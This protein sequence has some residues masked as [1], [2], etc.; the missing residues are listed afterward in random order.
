MESIEMQDLAAEATPPLKQTDLQ[1]GS[2]S[3]QVNTAVPH[4]FWSRH[5]RIIIEEEE[6][7]DHLGKNRPASDSTHTIC[8]FGVDFQ[9]L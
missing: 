1:S 3:A 2:Q 4:S 9:K 6:S 8:D 7:R 5:I